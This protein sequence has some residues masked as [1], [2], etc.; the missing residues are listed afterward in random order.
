LAR[1]AALLF[2]GGKRSVVRR[3]RDS[4]TDRERGR[5]KERG[6][7]RRDNPKGKKETSVGDGLT[8]TLE[9]LP[10]VA[11]ETVTDR[12]SVVIPQAS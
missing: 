1:V 9:L 4:E 5:I 3:R 10:A 8:D 11:E 7:V 2:R 6:K 12:G